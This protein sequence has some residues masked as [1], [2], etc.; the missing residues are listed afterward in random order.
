MDG[1]L[2]SFQSWMSRK[3]RLSSPATRKV[4]WPT[5]RK[6]D[7]TKPL[8]A[9][10]VAWL[11]MGSSSLASGSSS[12]NVSPRFRHFKEPY[13][14]GTE[15]GA[16]PNAFLAIVKDPL[17]SR[18]MGGFGSFGNLQGGGGWVPLSGSGG[19]PGLSWGQQPASPM[20]SNTGTSQPCITGAP[21]GGGTAAPTPSGAKPES[22]APAPAAAANS[23]TPVTSGLAIDP[24]C[25]YC[26]VRPTS[27]G[28]NTY[29]QYASSTSPAPSCGK[30]LKFALTDDEKKAA[31]DLHNA[32]RRFESIYCMVH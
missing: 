9:V 19:F 4:L 24:K 3:C 11:F 2:V 18:Q 28:A 27:G 10:A 6:V 7:P 17:L 12:S 23:S 5:M 1:V 21:Q 15:Y 32:Y 29:C 20:G 31:V 25:N 14:P 22:A 30:V 8:M 13:M 16:V 26:N